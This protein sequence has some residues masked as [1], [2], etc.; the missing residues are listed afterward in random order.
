MEY[1][2]NLYILYTCATGMLVYNRTI[3]L[4]RIRLKHEKSMD[5]DEEPPA[6]T[7]VTCNQN[8]Q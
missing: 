1:L 6:L 5:V 4:I 3:D 8:N 7:V 2:Y